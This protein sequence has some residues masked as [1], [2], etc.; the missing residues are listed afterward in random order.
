M[1]IFI[2]ICIFCF[3]SKNLLSQN[4]TINENKGNKINLFQGNDS[5]KSVFDNKKIIAPSFLMLLSL[6]L[7]QDLIK[8]KIQTIVR[9]PFNNFKTDIDWLTP[10]IPIIEL[11]SFD[12]LK[13]KAKNSIWNQTKYLFISNLFASTITY[14]LKHLLK[15]KRPD[16]TS[17]DS[18]PSGQ[19]SIAFVSSQVLWNEYYQTNKIIAFSGLVSSI[20]TGSLRVINNRHWLPDVLMGAGIGILTTNLI[21]H[22]KPLKNWNPWKKRKSSPLIIPISSQNY[23]GIKF[24]SNL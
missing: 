17:Y 1:R 8:T 15:I 7:N 9:K 3:I 16:E 24:V 18:Y 22:F 21:Y 2:S 13:F 6:S 11:Y 4:S 5:V 20:S 10:F 23:F 19:S 12:L 14:S